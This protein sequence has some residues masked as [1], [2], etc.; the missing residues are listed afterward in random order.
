MSTDTKLPVVTDPAPARVLAESVSELLESSA[1]VPTL[2]LVAGGSV[3]TDVLPLIRV[4]EDCSKLTVCVLD[5]RVTDVVADQ[6][7]HQLIQTP[8]LQ[9]VLKSG[10]TLLDAPF[11]RP[12]DADFMSTTWEDA[13][14]TWRATHPA[15]RVVALA[16]IGSDGHIAGVLPLA[17]EKNMAQFLNQAWVASYIAPIGMNQHPR[18]VTV[19]LTAFREL[20]DTALLYAVGTEKRVALEELLARQHN[21]LELPARIVYDVGTVTLYTDL[22]LEV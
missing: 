9:A 4:P 14:R 17:Q 10:G 13:L 20:I 3:R 1:R 18:R 11:A 6:N 8:W 15:A 16:G 19:T 2:L 21:L 22:T 7:H 5:E 12:T